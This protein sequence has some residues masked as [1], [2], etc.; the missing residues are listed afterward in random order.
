M[1]M[2]LA[3][4]GGLLIGIVLGLLGGGGALM[5]VPILIYVFHYPFR[6]SIGSGLVLVTLGVLP[7]LAMY[8][9][10]KQV[11][12]IAAL[13]MGITGMTGATLGSRY[14][15]LFSKE[16]LLGLLIVLMCLSAWRMF[17]GG[18]QRE[19]LST[20]AH[21]LHQLALAAAGFGIGILTGLVGVGGGFLLVP[22][23]LFLGKLSTRSAIATSLL[24]I[25]LNALA[26]AVG[27]WHLLPVGNPSFFWLMAGSLLGSWI[28]YQASLKFSE[29][30]LKKGFGL[31]LVMLAVLLLLSPP[32]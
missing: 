15:G 2:V 13:L 21:K 7:A 23:L 19:S 3:L 22:A 9:K 14:A 1:E 30:K 25:C 4:L 31:L 8:C 18:Q 24:I 12:W 5:A 20:N 17:Q 11:D 28:G 32:D 29:R 27:H 6:V 16:V 10:K 26:G